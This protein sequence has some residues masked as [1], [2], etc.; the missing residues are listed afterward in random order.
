MVGTPRR[1]CAAYPALHTLRD[2]RLNDEYLFI[3][4]ILLARSRAA[5]P[6]P[7][8]RTCAPTPSTASATL[9]SNARGAAE[10]P[11][12]RLSAPTPT[13]PTALARA[14]S[15][16]PHRRTRARVVGDGPRVPTV[17]PALLSY[18]RPP[19]ASTGVRLRRAAL[20]LFMKWGRVKYVLITRPRSFATAPGRARP[21]TIGARVGAR[22]SP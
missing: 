22:P 19:R 17:L 12:P 1:V 10:A 13:Q 11:P 2:G 7:R 15:A 14:I 20:T 9:H 18:T 16:A 3:L 4:C 8:T 21:R 6:A 5:P